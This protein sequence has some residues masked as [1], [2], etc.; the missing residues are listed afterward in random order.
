MLVVTCWLQHVG[1]NMLVVV[2]V[3]VGALR[4]VSL[5]F[6]WGFNRVS[7]G[8]HWGLN[9]LPPKQVIEGPVKAGERE[10]K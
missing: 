5:G 6:H 1:C 3:F 10:R 8:F 2:V 4:R 9:S 7:L